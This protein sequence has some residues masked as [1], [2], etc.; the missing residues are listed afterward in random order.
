MTIAQLKKDGQLIEIEPE[1][2][3]LVKSPANQRR[4]IFTK[5]AD[6]KIEI[7]SDQTFDGTKLIVNGEEL[8]DVDGFNFSLVN[9]SDEEM[10][11]WGATPF[12]AYWTLR[13]SSED[14]LDKVETY[15]LH[16]EVKKEMEK[17]EI[18][19]IAKEQLGMELD[20]AGFDKLPVEKRKALES[21]AIFAPALNGQPSFRDAVSTFVKA[22][23]EIEEEPPA[24][25][26][27]E[28]PLD[29]DVAALANAADADRDAKIKALEAKV[30]ELTKP[31]EGEDPE[32]EPVAVTK[33]D[34]EALKTAMDAQYSKLAEAAGV[35]ESGETDIE[36]GGEVKDEWSS[37]KV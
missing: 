36:K 3:S 17:S 10:E 19:K 27:P 35:K 11:E 13:Q 20:E 23:I 30:A 33:A 14:G 28:I 5:A 8:E 6:L 15:S 32:D 34:I 16:S 29:A 7:N 31:A 18:L 9:Y 37:W 25:D 22:G 12:S 26:P 2:V 4:F 1:K 24:D 21:L